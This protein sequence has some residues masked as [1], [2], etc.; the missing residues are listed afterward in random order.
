VG[1]NIRAEN[2][3][4][5]VVTGNDVATSEDWLV[6]L[7]GN[8]K[9]DIDARYV[10]DCDI[11]SIQYNT[12]GASFDASEALIRGYGPVSMT[13][14][15]FAGGVVDITLSRAVKNLFGFSRVDAYDGSGN[16]LI[17]RIGWTSTTVV[18]VQ[19]FSIDPTL[20]A[21]TLVAPSYFSFEFTG[22]LAA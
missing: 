18:R 19:F 12:S 16:A 6:D 17:P 7:G 10:G 15:E 22:E 4:G 13:A 20:G 1:G 5:L 21:R 11:Q 9:Y 14:V 3:E 2:T 8:T